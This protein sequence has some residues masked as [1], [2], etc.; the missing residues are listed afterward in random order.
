MLIVNII[1]TFLI[2]VLLS[3][4]RNLNQSSG[5]FESIS[6]DFLA[7]SIELIRTRFRYCDHTGKAPPKGHCYPPR[8]CISAFSKFCFS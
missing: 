8:G 1:V 4:S 3:E 5:K 6:N 2:C 7:N